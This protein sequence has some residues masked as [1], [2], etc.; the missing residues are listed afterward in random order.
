MAGR[1][2]RN[3][4]FAQALRPKFAV[5]GQRSRRGPLV[6]GAAVDMASVLC[7]AIREAK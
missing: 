5:S 1:D 7:R 3:A 2:L 4:R 6:Y